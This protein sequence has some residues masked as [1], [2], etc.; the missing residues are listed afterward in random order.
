VFTSLLPSNG[1]MC[2]STYNF[3]EKIVW[4]IVRVKGMD[5]LQI[6]EVIFEKEI[7]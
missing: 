3:G 7:E 5:T 4:H 2:H 6:F 1:H